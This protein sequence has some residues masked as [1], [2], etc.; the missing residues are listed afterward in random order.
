VIKGGRGRSRK[1]GQQRNAGIKKVDSD[2]CW[3]CSKSDHHQRN[4][5]LKQKAMKHRKIGPQEIHADPNTEEQQL[6]FKRVLV[7]ESTQL[8]LNSWI[9]DSGASDHLC[10]DY[11]AFNEIVFYL[12]P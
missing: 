4:C 10:S 12:N 6:H 3:Y 8:I 1:F 7:A 5:Y 2:I 11:F 9:I